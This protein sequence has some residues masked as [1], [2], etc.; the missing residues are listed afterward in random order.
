[1]SEYQHP[2]LKS[3]LKYVTVHAVNAKATALHPTLQMQ[4]RDNICSIRWARSKKM[5][6]NSMPNTYL[7]SFAALLKSKGKSFIVLPVACGFWRIF[8]NKWSQ[9]FMFRTLY[10]YYIQVYKTFIVY[11]FNTP[12]VGNEI[13]QILYEIYNR[14]EV[15]KSRLDII[16]D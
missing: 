6:L 1:M 9:T 15:Q 12:F 5:H 10:F 14:K 8:L 7:H 2:L 16:K 3:I 13:F 4:T 11:Y